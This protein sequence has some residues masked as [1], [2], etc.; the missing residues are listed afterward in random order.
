M[1]RLTIALALIV[2]LV[3]GMVGCTTTTPENPVMPNTPMSPTTSSNPGSVSDPDV[4]QRLIDKT[5]IS[6]AMVQIGNYYPGAR[7]EW[8]LRLH[9]GGDTMAEFL[10]SY[11]YPDY[12]KEGYNTAPPE[13]R[14][15]VIIT[16]PTPVLAP[17]ETREILV[18][19]AVPKDVVVTSKQW[20]FWVSVVEQTGG[21]VRTEM[22]SRWL[23]SM[24]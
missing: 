2:V 6:P 16:D 20:E 4:E 3:I 24:R 17:K 5:W 1:T 11:R 12:I 9:N 21:M 23:V 15:W 19:L 8:S 7:A 18:V 10:V 22:C 14:D 13:A